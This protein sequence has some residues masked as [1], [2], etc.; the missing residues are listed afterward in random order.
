[1]TKTHTTSSLPDGDFPNIPGI[2]FRKFRGEPDY[3][4]MTAITNASNHADGEEELT[5][6]EDIRNQY[7][8][9]ERLDPDKDML[10]VEF[11]GQVVGYCRCWWGTEANGDHLYRFTLFL[12]PDWRRE[13]IPLAMGTFLK[14]RLIGIA[15]EHQGEFTKYFHTWGMA[16]VVWHEQLMDQ[17]GLAPARN[18]V[19]M[20]RPCSLPI[21]IKPLP[22]GIEVRPT[23][24]EE[25]FRKIMD[26][27]SEACADHFGFVPPTE[28]DFQ[29]WVNGPTFDPSLWKVGWEGDQVVGMV[30]NYIDHEENK[31]FNRMRGYTED[32]SVRPAWRRQGIARALLSQSIKM[33][34]QMGMDET[35]LGVDAENPHGAVKFYENIGYIQAKTYVNY[36]QQIH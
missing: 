28:A 14:K 22:A 16:G 30:L 6:V 1:M 33:F 3:E 20:T 34:Q 8:H 18:N 19:T 35:A 23:T 31:A 5:T 2:T 25:D 24:G 9:M 10:F 4:A 27:D 29:R 11:E 26:A 7:N 36:R 17:L 12:H 13:G 32:I 15:A 21:E